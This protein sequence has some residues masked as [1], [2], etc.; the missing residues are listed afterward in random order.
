MTAMT[1][2][3]WVILPYLTLAVFVVGH[4]WRWRQDQFGWTTL[5]TQLQERRLLMWGS[6]L[7][8]YGAAAAI[9][10]HAI[11]L[12]IP[13]RWTAAVGVSEEVYHLFSSVAG[14]GAIL[15]VGTGLVI[16]LYR[17]WAMP[18]VR[19]TTR[20]VDV[21]V[22]ALLLIVIGLGSAAT[23]GVNL[24]GPGYEYRATVAIWFRGLFTADPTAPWLY[25]A[26]A[27]CAWLLLG[28]WPFSRLV[29]AWSYPIFYL[30]RPWIVYRGYRRARRGGST[31]VPGASC[32]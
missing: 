15:V 16:L 13:A 20:A 7:F 11:G 26:H 28:L 4:V 3:L 25:Q 1:W 32:G 21:A 8:H 6:P 18:R 2:L 31:A 29:H 14:T 22:Y 24:V 30:G 17:R 5:S 19:V 12:L 10:G 27:V 9:T 23:I